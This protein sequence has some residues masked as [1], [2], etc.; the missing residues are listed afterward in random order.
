MTGVYYSLL[1]A[2]AVKFRLTVSSK[3][4]TMSLFSIAGKD[5]LPNST[6]LQFLVELSVLLCIGLNE[7]TVLMMIMLYVPA[8]LTRV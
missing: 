2:D 4:N 6:Q 8:Q 7:E 5:M 1:Y 3:S